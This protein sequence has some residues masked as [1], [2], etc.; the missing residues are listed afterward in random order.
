M[1]SSSPYLVRRAWM[2]QGAHTF[3]GV[4]G[5]GTTARCRVVTV[6]DNYMSC[7]VLTVAECKERFA[8]DYQMGL[9]HE[10]EGHQFTNAETQASKKLL[11]LYQVQ[12]SMNLAEPGRVAEREQEEAVIIPL[13]PMDGDTWFPAA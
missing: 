9:V 8:I 4:F 11:E 1:K 5:S 7:E 3:I 6:M 10:I 12:Y 2:V 13:K